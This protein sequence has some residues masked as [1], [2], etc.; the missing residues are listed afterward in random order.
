MNGRNKLLESR[1]LKWTARFV[2]E[3]MKSVALLRRHVMTVAVP[4]PVAVP[5]A[6]FMS[7]AVA[8]L[9]SMAICIV[10]SR[11][12]LTVHMQLVAVNVLL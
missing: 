6:T 12:I 9:M 1:S 5:V 11:T 7:M 10:S 4:V 3:G 2:D 8:T